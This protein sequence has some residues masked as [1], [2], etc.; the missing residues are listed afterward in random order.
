MKSFEKIDSISLI[1]L[2]E[3]VFRLWFDGGPEKNR[4]FRKCKEY[5]ETD[6]LRS[7]KVSHQANP[8]TLKLP[9][10]KLEV[11]CQ[12]TYQFYFLVT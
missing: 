12:M 8:F 6:V 5:F 11:A 4:I 10:R 1:W 9:K 3:A 2:V 7:L